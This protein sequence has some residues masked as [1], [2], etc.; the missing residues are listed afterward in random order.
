MMLPAFAI[1]VATSAS[2]PEG[3]RALCVVSDVIEV[4]LQRRTNVKCRDSNRQC[5]SISAAYQSLHGPRPGA[6][7]HAA[8]M[9]EDG[10]ECE[11]GHTQRHGRA[12]EAEPVRHCPEPREQR[13]SSL[14]PY[15]AS[16][17]CIECIVTS[18]S[19]HDNTRTCQTW[20][21]W[22]DA[23]CRLS[24]RLWRRLRPQGAGELRWR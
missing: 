22:L 24:A 14:P 7:R 4:C 18:W 19:R 9:Q 6:D 20:I 3:D 23:T 13:Q 12:H 15:Q 17:H 21:A 2:D 16:Q 8:V 5:R 1:S 10:N 11:H